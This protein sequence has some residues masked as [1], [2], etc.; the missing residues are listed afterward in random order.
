[1]FEAFLVGLIIIGGFELLTN[2]AARE[3]WR[4][5][6]EWLTRAVAKSV[7]WLYDVITG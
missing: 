2:L 1:M 6:Y 3:Y 4:S 7:V 5:G